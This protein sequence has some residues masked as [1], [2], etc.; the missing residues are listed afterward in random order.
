MG[1]LQLTI[2]WYKKHL[3]GEQVTH[4]DIQ[5]KENS[6]LTGRRR[7]VS[8][9]PV[10]SLLTDNVFFVP[11]GRLLQGDHWVELL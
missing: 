7:F 11:C 2:T 6:N 1:P 4:W 9:V 8:D 10:R 3:V 5:N